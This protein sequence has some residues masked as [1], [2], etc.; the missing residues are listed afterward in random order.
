MCV[1]YVYVLFLGAM[2]AT[3]LTSKLFL[4]LWG[5]RKKKL[6]SEASGTPGNEKYY[7]RYENSLCERCNHASFSCNKSNFTTY[8]FL[9]GNFFP[10]SFGVK[11]ETAC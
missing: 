7:N 10:L 1:M 4:S 8:T 9:N 3:Y 6:V 5:Q 11:E 2:H